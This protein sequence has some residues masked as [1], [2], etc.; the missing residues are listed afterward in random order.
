MGDTK[1]LDCSSDVWGLCVGINDFRVTLHLSLSKCA[2][3]GLQSSE[4]NISHTI[5]SS[6]E[7]HS[8]LQCERVQV[9]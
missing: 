3:E 6:T 7:Q 1:S 2:L 4:G 5:L 9:H 8:K